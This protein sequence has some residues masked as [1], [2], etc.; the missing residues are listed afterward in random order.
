[1]HRVTG[2]NAGPDTGPRIPLTPSDDVTPAHLTPLPPFLPIAIMALDAKATYEKAL[3]TSHG[4]PLF[5]P[6]KVELGDVGYISSD[7]IFHTFFNIANPPQGPLGPK[8][9]PLEPYEESFFILG[10]MHVCVGSC[11]FVHCSNS[12]S[13]DSQMHHN[14]STGGRVMI[15]PEV[16]VDHQHSNP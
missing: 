10:P 7:G 5:T 12:H 6:R 9:I 2:A 15:T 1:M 4:F 16:S 3:H 11:W 13:Y 8:A 14:L